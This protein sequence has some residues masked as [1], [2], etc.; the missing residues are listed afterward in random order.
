MADAFPNVDEFGPGA[1]TCSGT[2]TGCAVCATANILIRYGKPIPRLSDG[3]PNMRELGRRMGARHRAAAAAGTPGDRHGLSLNGYC[4]G[5]T[6]WC[7]YCA[8]LELKANGL[9][10]VYAQLSWSTIENRLAARLPMVMPG[11]Y[12]RLPIVSEAS[13]SSTKPARGRSDTGFTGPHMMTAWQVNS[14][15]STGTIRDFVVSDPDFGSPSRPAVPPHSVISRAALKSYWSATGWAVCLVTKAPP[16][17]VPTSIPWWGSDVDPRIKSVYTAKSVAA[18][19]RTLGITNYG[20]AINN[21]DLEAGLKKR[22]INY[23]TSVQLVDVRALMSP[24]TGRP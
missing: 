18:K 19:L 7:A 5:G 17:T 15:T 24:G 10:A 9:P 4:Y 13:Y 3:T 14:R 23:G 1:C 6:N 8:M 22:G 11:L 2:M 12:G 16:A 21:I 20:K